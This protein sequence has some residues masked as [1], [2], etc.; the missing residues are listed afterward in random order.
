MLD[1]PQGLLR[2]LEEKSNM[3]SVPYNTFQLLCGQGKLGHRPNYFTADF[4]SKL[5]HIVAKPESA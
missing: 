4:L 5:A 1:K 2:R 3:N